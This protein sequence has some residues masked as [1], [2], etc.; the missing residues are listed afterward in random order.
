MGKDPCCVKYLFAFVLLC[1][2]A[3]GQISITDM[4]S[5]RSADTVAVLTSERASGNLPALPSAPPGKST[6]VGGE[7]RNVDQVLDQ[8]TLKVP[9]QRSTKILFDART[10]VYRDGTRISLRDLASNDYA[11]VE[12]VLNGTAVFALSVHI[13]SRSPEGEIQGQVRKY[14]PASRELTVNA[15]SSVDPIKLLVSRDV[16]IVRGSQAASSSSVFEPSDLAKGSVVSVKFKSEKDGRGVATRIVIQAAAGSASVF[17]GD[18]SSLD[19][20]SGL[21]VLIDPRDEKGYQLFFDSTRFP[22]S[23]DLHQGDHVSVT[24]NFDGE[25]YVATDIAVN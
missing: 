7:I 2:P 25:R 5:K 19:M 14:D 24:A 10:K 20:H 23:Q 11:S 12:T 21:L 9:G 4:Q 15:A 22:K 18:I 6:I 3:F 1:G 8:F 16:A 17:T 13:L